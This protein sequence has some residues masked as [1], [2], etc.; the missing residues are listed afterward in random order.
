[1]FWGGSSSGSSD[2]CRA[3]T[4]RDSSLKTRLMLVVDVVDE[5]DGVDGVDGVVGV[6]GVDGLDGVEM[7]EVREA[8]CEQDVGRVRVIRWVVSDPKG[9]SWSGLFSPAPDWEVM[10][11]MCR[12]RPKAVWLNVSAAEGVSRSVD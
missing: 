6:V 12:L 5:V 1:M 8:I 3:A 7:F 2:V 4:T 9:E 11:L 10:D